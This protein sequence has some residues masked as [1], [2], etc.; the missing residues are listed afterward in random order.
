M[1]AA[2]CLLRVAHSCS[3]EVLG[4]CELGLLLDCGMMLTVASYVLSKRYLEQ[5]EKSLANFMLII[6]VVPVPVQGL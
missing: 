1:L 6:S 4:G 2:A 5:F 3:S